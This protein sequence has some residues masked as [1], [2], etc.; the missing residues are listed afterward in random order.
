[1]DVLGVCRINN[2]HTLHDNGRR[3]DCNWKLTDHP[4]CAIIEY[5]PVYAAQ[6]N[7][8]YGKNLIQYSNSGRT[9]H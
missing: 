4:G 3:G 9:L 5:S 7:K 8:H 1:M 2:W 6:I